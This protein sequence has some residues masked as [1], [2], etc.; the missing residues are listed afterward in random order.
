MGMYASVCFVVCTEPNSG[1]IVLSVL[2]NWF[3]VVVLFIL[4]SDKQ[5]AFSK[6]LIYFLQVSDA[7]R[8]LFALLFCMLCCTSFRLFA[9]DRIT[10]RRLGC[11]FSDRRIRPKSSLVGRTCISPQQKAVSTVRSSVT[12]MA[13]C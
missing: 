12:F 8:V 9:Y 5:S 11:T 1:L 2:V 13:T 3:L 7:L 10:Y 4:L 6:I